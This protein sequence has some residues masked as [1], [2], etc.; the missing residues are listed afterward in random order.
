MSNIL[1]LLETRDGSLRPA[2]LEALG[3]AR[4]TV[5]ELGGGTVTALSYEAFD[6]DAA[7]LGAA[8]ADNVLIAGAAQHSAEGAAAT[9][10]RVAKELGSVAVLLAASVRGKDLTARIAAGLETGCV[11]DCTAITVADGRMVFTRPIYA[12]KGMLN[13]RVSGAVAVASLRGNFFA[14]ASRDA[15]AEIGE[16]SAEAS[17]SV[18]REVAAK[19]GG[20]PDVAE[21]NIVVAGGRGMGDADNWAMLEAI[22]DQLPG[23]AIGASRAVV[24]SGIRSHSEQ[25]GQTGK[26]VAPELYIAAGISGA[27]QHLAGMNNS[28]CIVA[29]NKDADAPIFTAA[30]YGIVGDINEVLPV[31]AEELSKLQN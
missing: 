13:A 3:A 15:A 2:S 30:T 7:L 29:I 9:C 20:R 25:V 23:A 16:T 11:P 8:G 27:I 10:T 31:L 6:A 19:S 26:T 17:K 18:V 22:A 24:D 28:K 12:G 1:V 5:D 4:K 21:A 14:A